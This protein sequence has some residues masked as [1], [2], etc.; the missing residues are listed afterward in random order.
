M[1]QNGSS[2]LDLNNVPS[3]K[4]FVETKNNTEEK[5]AKYN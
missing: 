4:G 3:L 1:I 5:Q 2:R